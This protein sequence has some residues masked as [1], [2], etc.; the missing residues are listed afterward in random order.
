[1]QS[2]DGL[3]FSFFLCFRVAP[4]FCCFISWETGQVLHTAST[5]QKGGPSPSR[6]SP[7]HGT[8]QRDW[9]RD[10]EHNPP[11]TAS[12][13]TIGDNPASA[14]PC[15]WWNFSGHNKHIA[16][17]FHQAVRQVVY[18]LS[19]ST[20]WGTSSEAKSLGLYIKHHYILSTTVHYRIHI[21]SLLLHNVSQINPFRLF[22]T[23]NMT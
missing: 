3:L 16:S 19:N 23:Y 18:I 17:D 2:T 6:R 13:R 1:V 21:S 20:E 12:P 5:K 4:L 10:L 9:R 11:I 15:H 14:L 7:L 22:Q 8:P